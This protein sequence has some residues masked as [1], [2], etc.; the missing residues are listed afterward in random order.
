MSEKVRRGLVGDVSR[1]A[2]VF[3]VWQRTCRRRP[4]VDKRMVELRLSSILRDFSSVQAKLNQFE[5]KL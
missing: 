1:V 4:V 5:D 2:K 3:A